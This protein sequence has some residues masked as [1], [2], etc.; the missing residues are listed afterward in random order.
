MRF[1]KVTC[2]VLYMGWGNPQYQY[3]MG[4]EGL[5]SSPTKKDLG[6]LVDE[7]MDMSWQC[8]LTAQKASCILGCIKRSVTSR[9][10]EVILPLYSALMRTYLEL[11]SP[12]HRKHMD[13][14]DRVQRRATKMIRGMEH[15]PEN[16]QGQV[17]WGSEQPNLVEDVPVH[18]RGGWT[19]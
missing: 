10:R 4:H 6:V 13:L 12:Q 18:C 16:I 1:N 19:R 11:W 8:A 9:S 17:E 3:R 14:L 7:K 2:K 15:I 5:E